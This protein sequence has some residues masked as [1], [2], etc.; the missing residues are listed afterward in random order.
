MRGSKKRGSH[1][2]SKEVV[3]EVLDEA[4]GPASKEVVRNMLNKERDRS[5]ELK[6]LA[7]EKGEPTEE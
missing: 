7:R 5:R 3:E 1:K 4:I 2:I 6:K